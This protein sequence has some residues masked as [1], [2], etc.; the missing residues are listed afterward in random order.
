MKRRFILLTLFVLLFSSIGVYAQEVETAVLPEN[1]VRLSWGAII[2]GVILA[3]V[4]QMVFNILGIAVGMNTINPQP[5]PGEDVVEPRAFGTGAMVWIAI[6]SLIALFI[7]GWLASRFSGTP[8]E[9]DGVLHGIMVWGVTTIITV[10]LLSTSIGRLM[11]GLSS[12]TN[13][14]LLFAQDAIGATVNV[15]GRAAQA[16]ASTAGSAVNRTARATA[17]AAGSAANAAQNA[18]GSAANAVQDAAQTGSA[19]TWTEEA[20]RQYNLSAD[21]VREE[22]RAVLRDADIP[23]EEVESRL[24]DLQEAV[25]EEAQAALRNPSEARE[26]IVN[27]FDRVLMEANTMLNQTDR[28]NL[29]RLL[30]VRTDMSEQQAQETISRWENRLQEARQQAEETGRNAQQQMRINR[31]GAEGAVEGARDYAEDRV[32]ELER[33][34]EELR[35]DVEQRIN[36]TRREAEYRVRETAEDAARTV[37]RLAAAI[38]AALIIGLASAGFGGFIGA[39]D[40]LPIAQIDTMELND[41]D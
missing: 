26:H 27:A 30:T 37:A 28:D 1:L 11:S 40:D 31:A 5:R 38:F 15:A 6:S 33:R 4:I 20:S 36:E 21:Q 35:D 41:A 9:L 22:L 39:T 13:Q 19:Q 8:N 3:L 18:A 34:V 14:I 25:S 24:Q 17:N 29:V 16:T 2:A 23:P 7:G 32:N 12:L 10:F